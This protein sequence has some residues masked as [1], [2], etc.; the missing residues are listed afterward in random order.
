M[1]RPMPVRGSAGKYTSQSGMS[2]TS[3]IGSGW[4]GILQ[5]RTVC[6]MAC[7]EPW[8]SSGVDTRHCARPPYATTSKTTARTDAR[9]SP[10]NAAPQSRR[11]R[12]RHPV[13]ILALVLLPS[14]SRL[15][16]MCFTSSFTV[17]CSFG[18]SCMYSISALEQSNCSFVCHLRAAHCV[19]VTPSLAHRR[20]CLSYCR[21][22]VLSI[23]SS[24][25]YLLDVHLRPLTLSRRPP[26]DLSSLRVAPSP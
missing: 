12:S 13:S 14:E 10:D 19:F 23:L 16:A 15:F 11:L 24:V 20:A 22:L 17:P 18:L 4:T 25:S 1:V 8:N 7:L 3:D 6:S 9:D 26:S 5:S 21:H 2:F